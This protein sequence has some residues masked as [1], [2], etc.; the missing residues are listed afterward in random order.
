MIFSPKY[1]KFFVS[2]VT[3]FALC[4]SQV[5]P[6]LTDYPFT[7]LSGVVSLG[8]L[9]G[10]TYYAH[11]EYKKEF[12]QKAHDDLKKTKKMSLGQFAFSSELKKKLRGKRGKRLLLINGACG[13][14]ALSELLLQKSRRSAKQ[15]QKGSTLTDDDSQPSKNMSGIPKSSTQQIQSKEN[16][17]SADPAPQVLQESRAQAAVLGAAIGDALGRVTEF[18]ENNTQGVSNLSQARRGTFAPYTDDTVMARIVLEEALEGRR[19]NETVIEISD[20]LARRFAELFGPNSHIIDP[21]YAV[22]AHGPTN[23]NSSRTLHGLI[24]DKKATKGTQWWRNR[25]DSSRADLV[26]REGGCGSVMRA[27]PLGLVFSSNLNLVIELADE[28]SYITHAHPMARASSAAMAVGVACAYQG[29]SVDAI[30]EQMIA[31]AEKFDQE[32]LRYKMHAQK[33]EKTENLTAEMLA[34]DQ[35]LTSDMIRYAYQQATAGVTPDVFLGTNNQK[36]SAAKAYRSPQ[37]FV[38]GWAADESVSAAV[39]LFVRHAD[40]IKQAIIEGVN[41]PGD[42]DS[43]A[44]LAGALV[45]AYSGQ[46]FY[47]E[48]AVELQLLEKQDELIALAKLI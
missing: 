41:T 7:V 30:V 22:R 3:G 15:E 38:L 16:A 29:M 44:T 39:Y 48:N 24:T 40:N 1:S 46:S 42:S 23:I 36:Q 25:I 5:Y 35:L 21:L 12:D 47:P 14:V 9:V 2:L 6:S 20:R 43:I 45:G 28:Q 10:E 33:R 18:T 26:V 19:N 34:Q 32:E 17:K 37:G 8:S 13:L 4:T 11:E 27:W 31:A